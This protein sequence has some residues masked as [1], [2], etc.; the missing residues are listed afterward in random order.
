MTASI[1]RSQ[2]Q[3]IFERSLM[4]L[5]SYIMIS[6]HVIPFVNPRLSS[7][8]ILCVCLVFFWQTALHFTLYY[9]YSFLVRSVCY[10]NSSTNSVRLSAPP[11]TWNF[12]GKLL[13]CLS[14]NGQVIIVRLVSCWKTGNADLQY[15]S[16]CV[17][18][19][20]KTSLLKYTFLT[21]VICAVFV[22]CIISCYR[23]KH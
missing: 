23:T 13:Y 10:G 5:P 2:R 20:S 6:F 8:I 1:L 16:V 19:W 9:P 7:N 18:A 21:A 3:V 14:W 15:G 11:F 22:Y 4:D 17:M 12:K